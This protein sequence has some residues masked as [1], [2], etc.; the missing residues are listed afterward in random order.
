MG[1]SFTNVHVRNATKESICIGLP[2]LTKD[3]GHVSA[4]KNGWVTVY[5]EASEDQVD[6]VGRIA[7]GLSKML[8]TDVIGF[9]VYDSDIAAYW[10]YRSGELIDEFNSAPNYFEGK[11][12]GES[13]AGPG[14][15]PD[16]LLP[17]CVRGATRAQLEQVLH[18]PDGYPIMA[19]E[20][21]G[22]LSKLLG[23]DDARSNLGFTYFEQQGKE[24]LPDADDFEPIGKGAER[25]E[26]VISDEYVLAI[27]GLTQVWS[28]EYEQQLCEGFDLAARDFLKKSTLRNLPTF[29]ELR[30]A[31]DK[32][33]EALAALIAKKTPAQLPEIGVSAVH[34]NLES[35]LAALLK[36]GLDPTARDPLGCTTL[37][38]A[39]RHGL[40]SSIYHLAKT[41]AEGKK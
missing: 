27:N 29:K 38:V 15:N 17:L 16:V 33:P 11:E 21:V 41:A 8:K 4:E 12:F 7:A 23:I 2:R 31:R 35:F 30:A 25:K 5:L 36:H 10:L 40:N 9:L 37:E 22:E 3:G 24:I 19:E 14:G 6:E 26:A 28:G 39:E 18:P 13:D 20:I 32:G 34:L 1:A